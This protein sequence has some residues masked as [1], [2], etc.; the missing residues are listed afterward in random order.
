MLVISHIFNDCE[1]LISLDLSSFKG[2]LVDNTMECMFI[3]CHNL[4]SLDLSSLEITYTYNLNNIFGGC[5]SLE[6]L[7]LSSFYSSKAYTFS[8]MFNNCTKLVSLDL[9]KFRGSSFTNSMEF[10]FSNCDNLKYLDLSSLDTSLTLNMSYMFNGC[11]SLTNLKLSK[12]NT[13]SVIDYSYMFNNCSLL[14]SIDL[15]KLHGS[16]VDNTMEYMFNNCKSL[17]SLDLSNL[18]TSFTRN[19]SYMFNNCNSLLSI[20][21]A[22]LNISS[23]VDFSYMFNNCSSLLYFN[24]PSFKTSSTKNTMEFMF[25]NC[26]N[27]K[28]IDLSNFNT[29]YTT[30]MKGIFNNCI[31][32]QN[33]KVSNFDASSVKDFSYMFNNCTSL[34]SLD[35]SDFNKLSTS[36]NMEYM[37]YNCINL[38]SL[39]L[40]KFD[41]SKT[42]NM[43]SIFSGCYSLTTLD[44]S[45]LKTSSVENMKEMFYNC[46]SLTSLDLFNFDTHSVTNMASMFNN[47][48]DLKYLKLNKFDTSSV[49]NMDLM[50]YNCESILSLNLSNFDTKNVN[51]M[52]KMFENC[53]SLIILDLSSFDTSLVTDMTSMFSGCTDLEFLNILKFSAN[54]LNHKN[55]FDLIRENIHFCLNN[56]NNEK[57]NISFSNGLN[58]RK[59]I[60]NICSNNWK[61]YQIKYIPE[62]NECI[63]DCKNH[64]IYKYEFK[65]FCYSSCP[66]DSRPTIDDEFLC[67]VIC[68]EEK[69]YEIVLLYECVRNC[70]AFNF[71][72]KICKINYRAPKIKDDMTYNIDGDVLYG[73]L[74][75]MITMSVEKEK[76]DLLIK[77]GDIYYQITSPENQNNSNY[78]NF[79]NL[80]IGEIEYQLKKIYNLD[81]N[82]KLVIFKTDI[83]KEGYYIPI[84]EYNIYNLETR[85]KLDLNNSLIDDIK[86][87]IS[88]PVKIDEEKIYKYDPYSDYYNDFCFTATTDDG[89]DIILNDRK[90]EFSYYNLSLCEKD[91]EYKGYDNNLKTAKCECKIKKELR[92]F[93]TIIIDLDLLFNNFIKFSYISNI[94]VIKCYNLLF[95]YDGLIKNVG[96]YIIIIIIIIFIVIFILFFTVGYQKHLKKIIQISSVKMYKNDKENEK[97]IS[98]IKNNN[99]IEVGNASNSNLFKNL[100][101]ENNYDKY[102]EEIKI[103]KQKQINL[104]IEKI[105]RV[106]DSEL[107]SLSYNE[108]LIIDKRSYF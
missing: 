75:E 39:N 66:P 10:M 72:N 19:L 20:N 32:L 46:H 99:K 9:S 31:S 76:K 104:Q 52:S 91:C 8:F 107:N 102:Q 50:F 64:S 13:S 53:Y 7:N 3:N 95:T 41:T 83:I 38:I 67:E 65:G 30:N 105:M 15:S 62:I 47:C 68:T 22:K 14:T 79:T 59:C 85:E 82:D 55:M 58:I 34:T 87:N 74:N 54:L 45:H 97:D 29:S 61:H 49:I 37:F 90:D 26:I 86:I 25:N 21:I 36:N 57:S 92:V 78:G 6:Y 103:E 16:T 106:N 63:D 35:L 5:Y 88:L 84:I 101:I 12:F 44:L 28:S 17:I 18:D 98:N 11:N 89:T 4:I 24:L 43:D 23:M 2:S 69:P 96:S 73:D 77:S 60:K 80:G 27:L 81:E 100:K 48:T 40:S 70:S 94:Y 1:S 33:L 71:F 42:S 93:S 56:I 51:S 108:D